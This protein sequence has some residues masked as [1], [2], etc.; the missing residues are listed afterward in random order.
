MIKLNWSE[1]DGDSKEGDYYT[2]NTITY[3]TD[4]ITTPIVEVWCKI[5]Y[6]KK[7]KTFRSEIK[8]MSQ[9]WFDESIYYKDYDNSKELD[10]IKLELEKTMSEKLSETIDNFRKIVLG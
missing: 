9:R 8:A 5:T 4:F 1:F 3:T 10:E 6:Y 2:R 7:S